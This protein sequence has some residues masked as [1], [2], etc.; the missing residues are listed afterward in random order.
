M[1]ARNTYRR[2]GRWNLD[3]VLAKR[4]R[5]GGRVALQ[6][7]LEI[8]NL[9]NHAN[10][11]IVDYA[12]DTTNPRP[13]ITAFRGYVPDVGGLPGDGQRRLQLGARLEF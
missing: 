12:T 2:P 8:Y 3:A 1:E 6:V 13:Q 10:L 5:F 7:R 9:F 11:N 4:F